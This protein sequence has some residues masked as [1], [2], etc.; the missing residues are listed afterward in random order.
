M[1][2]DARRLSTDEILESDIC[3]IGGG[4]AG[5]AVAREFA[6]RDPKVIL[7]ES[8]GLK[9]EHHTQFLYKIGRAHV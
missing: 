6:N 4:A 1:L 2:F 9:F 5:I 3:I 8:G 7:L